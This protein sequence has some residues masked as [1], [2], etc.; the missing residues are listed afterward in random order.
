[1][2]RYRANLRV[3]VINLGRNFSYVKREFFLLFNF[4]IYITGNSSPFYSLLKS[5]R[6]AMSV[7]HYFTLQVCKRRKIGNKIL[8]PW[9]YLVEENLREKCGMIY[10][11]LKRRKCSL[12]H[13]NSLATFL[14]SI[15]FTIYPPIHPPEKKHFM[16]T[17]F[18]YD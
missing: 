1:M 8:R 2:N 11:L 3:R 12:F 18:F 9:I 16:T 7:F 4:F 5:K 14:L 13:I 15:I 17:L 10:E 6:S